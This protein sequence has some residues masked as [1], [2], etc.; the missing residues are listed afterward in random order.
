MTTWIAAVG[1][2]LGVDLAVR[3]SLALQHADNVIAL[4]LG[5]MFL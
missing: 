2:A 4:G 5:V 3:G 1:A